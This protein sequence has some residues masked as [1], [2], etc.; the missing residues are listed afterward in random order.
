M[1][2]AAIVEVLELSPVPLTHAEIRRATGIGRDR[3]FRMLI[4]LRERGVIAWQQIGQ[5]VYYAAPHCTG[6]LTELMQAMERRKKEC[7]TRWKKHER[8]IRKVRAAAARDLPP[9]IA[10]PDEMDAHPIVRRHI[11]A[12]QWKAGAVGPRWVFDLGA[13]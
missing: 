11:P 13:V 3:C 9:A 1:T 7:R 12:G 6:M 5:Q 10:E 8:Q 4:D 2:P